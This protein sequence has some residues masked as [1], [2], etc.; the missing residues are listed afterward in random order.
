MSGK[1]QSDWDTIDY[2]AEGAVATVTLDRPEYR[3]AQNSKMLYEIDDAITRAVEDPAVSVIVLAGR[4][5]HFSAGHDLGTPERDSDMS[6]P[7]RALVWW[8]HVRAEG[9]DSRFAREVEVYLGL[10]RRWADIPK[11][12][13]AQVQGACIAGGLMLA[14]ACDFIVASDDAFFA[15]PVVAMGIP[16]VEYFAHPYA[17]NPRVAKEFLFTGSRMS[18]ARAREVGMVNHVVPRPELQEFTTELAIR[19]AAMPR[20]GLMLA[21][22]A[23]NQAQDHQG[24]RT[25]MDAA[26][27]LHHLAHAHNAEVGGGNHLGGVDLDSL[28]RRNAA[29]A[30]VRSDDDRG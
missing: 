16:G 19:I 7:R 24:L 29:A 11:P 17:M 21:K 22:R 27:G 23:V 14:W 4:G 25:T 20:F 13:I 30:E 18:A 5:D 15:D 2:R 1:Q 10:C 6:Y 3:N 8:D 12:M 26:F 9:G 28:R